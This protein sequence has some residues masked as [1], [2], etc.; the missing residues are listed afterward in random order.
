MMPNTPLWSG[1]SLKKSTMALLILIFLISLFSITIFYYL[2]TQKQ[3]EK[4]FFDDLNQT[5][6]VLKSASDRITQ[7]QMLWESTYKFPLV[8]VTNL[9]I[10]EY[11]AASLE[12]SQMDLTRIINRIDPAYRDRIDIMLINSSGVA[13]YSTDSN[14]LYLDFSTWGPFY[15]TIT[16]MRMNNS[17]R[18]D[19]AVRG[20]D[21]NNPWRIFGYQPTPDH[22]YLIEATYRI[23]DD[24]KEEREKLSLNALVNQITAQYP[25]IMALDLIG[26]TGM[27]ISRVDE[28][29]AP[30]DAEDYT[31]CQEV[32]ASHITRDILD[33][34]NMTLI[35]FFFIESGDNTSP[36]SDYI[37][38]V[39]KIVFSTSDYH[40]EKAYLLTLAIS[41]LFFSILLAFFLAYLLSRALFSPVEALLEDLDII[42]RGDINH[43]IRQ[44]RHQE[45]NRIAHAASLMI[46]SIKKNIESLKSSEKRYHSLFSN[47]SDGIILWD[48]WRILSANP[49]AHTLFGWDVV[50]D[51]DEIP[52]SRNRLIRDLISGHDIT[53]PEWDHTLTIPQKSA[54]VL[55][56]RRVSIILDNQSLFLLQIRD[57]TE[58]T[59]MHEEIHHLADIVR[60]TSTG[61]I[62]GPVNSPFIVNEAYAKMHGYTEKQAL[63]MGF[64]GP[65]HPDNRADIPAWLRTAGDIGHMTGEALRIRDDKSEFPALHDLTIIKN[66]QG[67][68]YLI[69]NVQD[70]TDQLQVWRLTL[71]KESLSVSLNLFNSILAHLPDPTFAISTNGTILSWNQAMQEFTH[72]TARAIT[73]GKISYS[74]AIYH[75]N[76]PMLIDKVLQPDIDLSP[77]YNNVKEENGVY[78]AEIMYETS[79]GQSKYMWAVAGRLYDNKG[80]LIGAIETIRDITELKDAHKKLSDLNNKLMLLSSLTRHDLRNKITVIDG[81]RFFAESETK[82][83]KI[84]EILALQKK[85]IIDTG[86]LIDFSKTYQDI[87]IQEPGWHTVKDLFKRSVRQVSIDLQWHCEIPD[88]DIYAD[89]LVAQV[90][91]NLAENSIRHGNNVKT[92]SLTFETKEDTGMLYY[93]DDGGGISDKEKE[94]IFLRGYGKNTGL[95][96]FLIREILAIT[97]ITISEK[98][99]YGTGVRFEIQIPHSR[100]RIH[101]PQNQDTHSSAGEA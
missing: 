6:F 42:A 14:N 33:E 8:A 52:S 70:I 90:F 71:E 27:I 17:F 97:D 92:V 10:E 54:M 51:G 3:I 46:K 35:R 32:Y 40:Q 69:L 77:Y 21:P 7:G 91:Y 43:T 12:P 15:Q 36:A 58:E 96:L 99:V 95:G 50:S 82:E 94:Q 29:P 22:R 48:G 5:E 74:T 63:E 20:F 19:R 64:F 37:D 11:E 24:Y 100:Y 49:A 45:V 2:E 16:D 41:L 25:R 47:A 80:N 98:G 31:I 85:V 60:N 44:S 68:D 61:I 73:E 72:T 62:A 88:M 67:V 66:Q 34:K 87:G 38:F 86:K 84:M 26:S 93:E 53:K 65:V 57:I 81:F 101:T 59:R 79:G 75:V 76:R 13:E 55:N 30:I 78:S 18:L 28:V 56:I 83:E 39:G 89:D 1:L 9:V 23:Y 4:K